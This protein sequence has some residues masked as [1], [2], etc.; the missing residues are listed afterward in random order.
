M[1]SAR[2]GGSSLTPIRTGDR[3]WPVPDDGFRN[4]AFCLQWAIVET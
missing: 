3:C 1:T 2:P 4:L